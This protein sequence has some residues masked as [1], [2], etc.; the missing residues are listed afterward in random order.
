M[1]QVSPGARRYATLKYAFSI[2]DTAYLALL[3]LLFLG[4]GFSK[5]LSQ[6][7]ARMV[8]IE[9]LV[10]PAYLLAVSA[11]Y[12]LLNFPLHF[13]QAFRLEHAF[14]LSSQTLKDWLLD[15]FKAG[16]ISYLIFLILAS[17]FYYILKHFLNSWWLVASLF[18]IFFSVV[19]AKLVPIVIVPL[20]FKYK[21][22]SD[23]TLR[24][25]IIKLAEKMKIKVID[26]FEIDFSK[27]T[28]KANAAYLGWAKTKRV[29]LADTLKDK[30]THDEIEVVLA[31]EFA[32]YKMKHIFRLISVNSLATLIVFFAIF[33]TSD[34][35]LRI[36][37]LASLWDIA[38]LPLIVLYFLIINIAI[39][40][41]ACYFSRRMERAA[42]AMAL[43]V[44]GLNKAFVSMMDKLSSQ[45]LADRNPHPLIKFFFFDHPPID[46]RIA[47]ARRN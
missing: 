24:Q 3:L 11:G 19:M 44:T 33:K 10:L 13:L 16:V 23:E 39:Q 36:F 25:R 35:A 6:N 37:G 20:F 38:A 17:A 26:V 41:M 8:T 47:F 14:G 34:S 28:V 9:Y 1:N 27:K 22:I 12:Y 31:H 40:P 4:L 18:W 15:E 7:L 46:E 21:K 5:M 32:H 29:I 45:N 42:D 43:E 2:A 30:Y